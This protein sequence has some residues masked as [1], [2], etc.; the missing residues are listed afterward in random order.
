MGDIWN[1]KEQYKRQMG[2]LWSRGD[3]GVFGGG[4]NPTITDEM[5]YLSISTTGNSVDFGNLVGLYAD[6]GAYGNS[7]RG[8]FAKGKSD[9]FGD[10]LE[11]R[12]DFVTV[13]STGNAADFGD[14]TQG[15]R[16]SGGG[17]G[18]NTRAI[19]SV[20]GYT[21]SRVNTIDYVTIATMGDGIDFGDLSVARSGANCFGDS[22][23]GVI[24]GGYGP[25][26]LNTI[27]YLTVSTLG[28]ATD[29]GDLTRA[30]TH[31]GSADSSTR[32]V[33]A[34]GGEPS[35][36]NVIHFVTIASTGDAADFGD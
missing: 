2:N 36:S 34:G 8:L 32:G 12:I 25:A 7:T 13:A 20:G 22:T 15:T 35:L 21:G 11:D 19:P 1:I 14:M 3:R 17:C 30:V 26:S 10:E 23:R 4:Y 9:P 31:A 24:S 6:G 27:D 28:D 16:G 5:T 29:F 33:T 18:D